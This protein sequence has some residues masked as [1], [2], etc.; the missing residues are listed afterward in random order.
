MK[1]LVLIKNGKH[2]YEF[3]HEFLEIFRLH[4]F[5]Y[6]SGRDILMELINPFLPDFIFKPMLFCKAQE[7]ETTINPSSFKVQT[8][9]TEEDC[10]KLYDLLV[11][12]DEFGIKKQS[13]KKYI[14]GKMNSIQM[15][16]TLY[17][18]ENNKIVSTVATTAETT[19]SAMVVAVATI[20]EYRKKGYASVLMISLMKEYFENR[21][22]ELCL[23]YDNPKAGKIYKK[24]GFKDI[25]KWVMTSKKD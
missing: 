14:E 23:F 9:K 20:P 21:H 22:K 3:N 2:L 18:E 4:N 11:E 10:S 19:K 25:G 13:R 15:G 24:L 7:I 12:I 1:L 17:I 16:I 6:M 8:V 5:E